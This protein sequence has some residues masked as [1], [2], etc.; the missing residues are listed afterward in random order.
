MLP[1]VVGEHG[2]T[3]FDGK[4]VDHFVKLLLC[5]LMT[6]FSCGIATPWAQAMYLKWEMEHTVVDGRR[7]RFAGSGSQLFVKNLKWMLLSC[8]TCGI[9]GMFFV[10]VNYK[11]WAWEQT[12]R[13][14]P[15]A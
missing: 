9:Y 6:V 14:G 13:D 12:F 7:L 8:I 11:K 2:A 10:P 4:P 5:V 1:A 15:P 3:Y